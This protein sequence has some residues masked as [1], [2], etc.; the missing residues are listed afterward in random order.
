MLV[1]RRETLPGRHGARPRLDTF[2]QAGPVFPAVG[3]FREARIAHP[4]RVTDHL[5]QALKGF[6]AGDRHHHIA[7]RRL[8]RTEHWPLRRLH[9][10][11]R[12]LQ[13]VQR[14]A[15]HRFQHRDVDMLA[16]P[17]CPALIQRRRDGAER[18]D[19][20]EHVGVVDAAIIRPASSRLVRQMRHLIAGGRVNHRR[21]GRQLGRRPGLAISRDRAINQ[22][23]VELM[24]RGMIELQ[25]PHHAGA[26]IFHQHVRGR[27]EAAN[28]FGALG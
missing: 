21:I 11:L 20:G 12:P 5:H 13:F 16:L 15:Q 26:E 14:Q 3:I 28:G 9:L 18:V 2:H 23:R 6:L 17:G 27:D 22:F 24:Q 4:F 1:E 19:A 25:S 7:V 10:E 8:D